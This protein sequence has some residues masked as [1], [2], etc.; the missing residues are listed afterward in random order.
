MKAI[1][2]WSFVIGHSSLA[3]LLCSCMYADGNSQT[4][5]W[6]IAAVGTDITEHDLSAQGWKAVKI[7]NSTATKEVATGAVKR[8]RD[9]LMFGLA[10]Q[11]VDMAKDVGLKALK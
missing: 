1:R 5:Q 9:A 10:G 7:D 8:A 2:H 11:G 6:R 4:G 3:L